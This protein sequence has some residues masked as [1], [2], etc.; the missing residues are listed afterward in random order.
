MLQLINKF[1]WLLISKTDLI[2]AYIIYIS[3]HIWI[4]HL[5]LIHGAHSHSAIRESIS[6]HNGNGSENIT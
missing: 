4:W 3:S 1:Y 5:D 2:L 6:I